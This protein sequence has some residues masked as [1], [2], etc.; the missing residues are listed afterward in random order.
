MKRL[1]ILLAIVFTAV[2]AGADVQPGDVITK[3]NLDKARALLS[4]HQWCVEHGLIIKV[5]APRKSSGHA[6]TVKPPRRIAAR[7]SSQHNAIC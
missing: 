5:V 1:A 3:D 2:T 4:R 6:R 7:S